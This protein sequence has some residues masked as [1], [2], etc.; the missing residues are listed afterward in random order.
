MRKVK[1]QA[2]VLFTWPKVKNKKN[3]F[4]YF[5]FFFLKSHYPVNIKQFINIWKYWK[6]CDCVLYFFNFVL[7]RL[8]LNR[9][10][11]S[12]FIAFSSSLFSLNL[13]IFSSR[14]W[15]RLTGCFETGFSSPLSSSWSACRYSASFC[16]RKRT[17]RLPQ[18]YLKI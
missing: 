18:N 6:S 3:M 5:N 13:A 10:N 11:L 9:I 12:T 15:L 16:S 14:V 2:E 8:I 17:L 4:P 1:T 7:C